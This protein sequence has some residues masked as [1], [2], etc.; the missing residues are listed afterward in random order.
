MVTGVWFSSDEEEPVVPAGFSCAAIS[1]KMGKTNCGTG[2]AGSGS[3][4]CAWLNAG[5]RITLMMISNLRKKALQAAKLIL[6]C[7]YC[8]SVTG[9][10]VKPESFFFYTISP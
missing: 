1:E 5:H 7:E 4:N 6:T 9:L 10:M 8:S 3:G 2:A